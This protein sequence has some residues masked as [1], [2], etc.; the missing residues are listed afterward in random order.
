MDGKQPYSPTDYI[1]KITNVAPDSIGEQ[2]WLDFLDVIFCGDN[3]LISYVQLVCGLAAIGKVYQEALIIAYGGGKNGKSTFWNTVARVMGTYSGHI[4]A[5]TLALGCRRNIKP[6]LAAIRG[7][8]LVIAAE[9]HEGALLNDSAL[10]QLCSTDEILGEAKYK[11]P[12]SFIPTHT[13]VLYTNNLPKPRANDDGTWRRMI[14]IPFN[15]VINSDSEIKNY[16][17]YLLNNAGGA[18]MK[19]IIEGAQ[20][21]INLGC[22]LTPPECIQNAIE[23]FRQENDWFGNFISECCEIGEGKQESASALYSRYRDFCRATNEHVRSTNDFYKQMGE[24]FS[25]RNLHGYKYY[26]GIQL[27]EDEEDDDIFG[28]SASN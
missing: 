1:T 16:G 18:V 26:E 6:E 14:V 28:P 17:D 12:L 11:A 21:A 27:R 15:A 22:R 24:R 3:D 23:T 8:R 25:K 7:K 13:A 4:S 19:W 5:D 2:I 20:Q 9:L 10:K